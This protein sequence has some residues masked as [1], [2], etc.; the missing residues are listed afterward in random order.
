MHF[1]LYLQ[2]QGIISAE[3]LVAAIAEQFHT[4]VPIGQLALEEGILSARDIFTVLRS[5]SDSPNERFGEVAIELGMMSRPQLIHLLMLQADRQRPVSEI[6][7]RQGAISERDCVSE[8]ANYRLDKMQTRRGAKVTRVVR[9]PMG[10]GTLARMA[11]QGIS[12]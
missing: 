10:Q 2:K 1:G 6:L 12:V 7:V 8:L 5:Q 4:R 9:P 11:N 3:Q